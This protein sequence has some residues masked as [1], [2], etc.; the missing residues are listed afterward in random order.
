M[1]KRDLIES[2]SAQ[3]ESIFNKTGVVPPVWLV[4]TPDRRVLLPPPPHVRDKDIAM[5]M[6]R[7][8]LKKLDATACVYV[9]EAWLLMGRA[10]KGQAEI[11]VA[12]VRGTIRDHPERVE[13]VVFNAEDATGMLM[14]YREI[15]RRPGSRARLGPLELPLQDEPRTT[16]EGRMVGMLPQRGKPQ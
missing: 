4:T 3:A 15:I 8:A 13:V 14:G 5:A 2:A 11:E 9:D 12:K 16:Y 1:T 6:I 10:A 7:V